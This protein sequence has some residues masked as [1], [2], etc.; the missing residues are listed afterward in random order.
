MTAR[1]V[2]KCGATAQI[3]RVKIDSFERVI[4]NNIAVLCLVVAVSD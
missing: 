3:V 4:H 2:S 1:R